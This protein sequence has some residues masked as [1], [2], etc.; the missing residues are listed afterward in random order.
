MRILTPHTA[1][2][3]EP[4]L[5]LWLAIF[6][7]RT[8]CV[9]RN[10]LTDRTFTSPVVTKTSRGLRTLIPSQKLVARQNVRTFTYPGN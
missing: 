10:A 6:P 2:Q 5:L 1:A 9:D 7:P 3:P 8:K 4:T